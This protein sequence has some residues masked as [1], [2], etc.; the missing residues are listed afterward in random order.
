[1]Y[2]LEHN[3]YA[4]LAEYYYRT[5]RHLIG[6]VQI[7]EYDLDAQEMREISDKE[8]PNTQRLTCL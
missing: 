1:M 3:G 4:T 6:D 8:S 5:N 7:I 2:N